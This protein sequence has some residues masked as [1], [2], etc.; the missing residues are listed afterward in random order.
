MIFLSMV[1]GAVAVCPDPFSIRQKKFPEF[2][3][4]EDN[5]EFNSKNE[6]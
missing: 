6:G 4:N 3:S 1:Q 5:D 2:R